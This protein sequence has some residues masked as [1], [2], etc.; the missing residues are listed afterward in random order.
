MPHYGVEEYRQMRRFSAGPPARARS[1]VVA[2]HAVVVT[3]VLTLVD[4]PNASAQPA[5]PERPVTLVVPFAAGGPSDAIARL[6]AQSMSDTL[7]QQLVIENVAGA[8]GTVAA[9]RV[10]RAPADGYTL[11]IHHLALAT[12]ETLY[13]NRGYAA[14]TAF[15]PIGLVNSGP[16]VLTSKTALPVKTAAELFAYIKQNGQKA[17]LAHAG[18]GSGSYLCNLM[19]EQA[20]GVKTAQIAY[21]GTGPALN[22]VVAGQVDILCDQ[23][24]NTIPQIKAGTIRA[25]ATTAKDRMAV[26]PELPTMTDVGMPQIGITVWHALYVPAGTPQTIRDALTS[27]LEKAL[28]DKTIATR[29]EDFGTY[30]FAAGKRGQA[31]ARAQL[32]SEIATWAKLLKSA[33]VEVK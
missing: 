24:T 8:G 2:A 25:Y 16:Y 18:V 13:P 17:T 4:A 21:R 11:L 27:A 7:G 12:G 15:D 3:A 26:L 31:A 33:G 19:L 22:D 32:E 10:A 23:T 29:F 30:M 6:L 1:L 5:Y 9:A 14:P 20:L 28:K